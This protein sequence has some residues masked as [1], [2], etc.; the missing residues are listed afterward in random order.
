MGLIKDALSARTPI[1]RYCN[2]LFHLHRLLYCRQHYY[3]WCNLDD[4]DLDAVFFNMKSISM[5]DK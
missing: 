2:N 1:C 4:N 5:A 3:E